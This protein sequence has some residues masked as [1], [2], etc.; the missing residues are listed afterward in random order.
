MTTAVIARSANPGQGIMQAH[1][2][3]VFARM[4]LLLLP[5]DF[6]SS[7]AETPRRLVSAPRPAAGG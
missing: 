1:V 7:R 6:A 2:F 5:L 4:L 3:L